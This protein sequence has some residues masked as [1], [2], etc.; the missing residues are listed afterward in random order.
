MLNYLYITTKWSMICENV[1]SSYASLK[2]VAD[3][4]RS[5]KED[6]GGEDAVKKQLKKE[7]GGKKG[8][9]KEAIRKR[10]QVKQD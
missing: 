4:G 7:G 5:K 8:G 10:A 3:S 2:A 1:F 9:G 6:G